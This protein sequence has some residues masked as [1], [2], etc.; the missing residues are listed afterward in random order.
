MLQ[1]NVVIC[2]LKVIRNEFWDYRVIHNQQVV[3][4]FD[5]IRFQ[6]VNLGYCGVTF[7]VRFLHVFNNCVS[8][9]IKF[10]YIHVLE[11]VV[12]HFVLFVR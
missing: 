7:R 4:Y 6:R 3:K 12:V 2:R 10:P 5:T 9:R 11:R 8:T 1:E